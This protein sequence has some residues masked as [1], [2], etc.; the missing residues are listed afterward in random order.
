M[1]H[2]SIISLDATSKPLSGKLKMMY[3]AVID[4]ESLKD[5]RIINQ[6]QIS[7]VI[8][9]YEPNSEANKYHHIF[10]IK[11]NPEE[12]EKKIDSIA[13]EMKDGW[14]AF[15]WDDEFLFIAFDKQ[16]FKV[17]QTKLEKDTQYIKAQKYGRSVGIQDEFLNFKDYF[18][19]Y[20]KLSL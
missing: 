12:I 3:F 10:F 17:T 9:E 8:V 16:T 2:K 11:I 7:K 5:P 18:E 1:F 14:Y 20:K 19:R 15:F 6:F 4:T 13:K